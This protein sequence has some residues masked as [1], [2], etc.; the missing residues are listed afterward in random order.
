MNKFTFE[1]TVFLRK[2]IYF[3]VAERKCPVCDEKTSSLLCDKCREWTEFGGKIHGERCG[4][5]G[6]LLI[7][8][9]DYCCDCRKYEKNHFFLDRNF[10][11]YPYH[12]RGK[13]LLYLWKIRK[14]R[15]LGELFSE[16]IMEVK[17]SFFS[18]FPIVPV[19]PRPEKIIREGWDQ[20]LDLSY[21]LQYRYKMPILDY[22]IRTEKRQQKK[23]SK[24]ER[25]ENNDRYKASPLLTAA[26]TKP[27]TV[28]LLDDIYTTGATL[29]N[30]AK[31]LKENGIKNVYGITLFIVE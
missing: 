12:L 8:E 6:K 9:K 13:K 2:M 18:D 30:C 27:E 10:A 17:K 15:I 7:S 19:P 14:N 31:V 28:V 29:E 26:K 22:L 1:T 25:L 21:F 5:C 24:K 4:Q 20:I 16:K 11:I 3:A 23:L